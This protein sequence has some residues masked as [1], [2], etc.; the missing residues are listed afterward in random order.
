MKDIIGA[1]GENNSLQFQSCG[2]APMSLANRIE[3]IKLYPQIPMKGK[4]ITQ[5]FVLDP[6]NKV[7]IYRIDGSYPRGLYS[8]HIITGTTTETAKAIEEWPATEIVLDM[9]NG[10]EHFTHNC[11]ADHFAL[12]LGDYQEEL[13][14]FNKMLNIVSISTTSKSA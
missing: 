13:M 10:W 3:D 7:T 6:D 12:V 9:H 5:S 8:G 11:T 1:C 4:G 2:Y 14:I